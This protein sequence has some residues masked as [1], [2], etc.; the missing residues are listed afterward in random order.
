MIDLRLGR[1]EDALADVERVDAVIT[2][3]PYS[4][5]THSAYRE[6]EDV[7]RRPIGYSK[8]S[9]SDVSAFVES[10][11]PRCSGWFVALTDHILARSWEAHLEQQGR[12][13]FSPLACMEIGSRVRLSGDGPCQWSVWT[14]VSRPRTRDFAKWGAL[15][16]GYIVPPNK[17]WRA[18][19]RN[20]CMGSKPLH[21]MRAIVR[22]YSRS[23]DLV[24][25]PCAGGGTTLLAAAMEGRR[26]IGA[27]MDPETHAKAT[28]RLEAGYTPDMF[29]DVP[30]MTI[31]GEQGSLL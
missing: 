24:C 18:G 22:D 17:G 6:M 19:A 23:G 5:R 26:A 1:W 29:A 27:E 13:V 21:L 30:D 2:D 7:G 10:W 16:G 4:D 3:T 25:D 14:V 12:Y 9:D 20:G 28:Q 11:A 15:P 31:N 8:W